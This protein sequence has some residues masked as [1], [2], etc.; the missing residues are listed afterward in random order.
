MQDYAKSAPQT[1]LQLQSV[2]IHNEEKDHGVAR[3]SQTN[4]LP[5]KE[6]VEKL[7]ASILAKQARSPQI[8]PEPAPN[9]HFIWTIAS[10]CPQT[11]LSKWK[12]TMMSQLA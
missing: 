8:Y 3:S 11:I 6:K 5:K 1:V 7:G 2:F 4:K 9:K 12:L 10:I